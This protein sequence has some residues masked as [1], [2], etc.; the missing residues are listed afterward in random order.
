[1]Q[2]RGSIVAL[3]GPADHRTVR[4]LAEATGRVLLEFSPPQGKGREAALASALERMLK[5]DLIVKKVMCESRD[6]LLRNYVPASL[7]EA[8]S[9]EME[10]YV[11]AI[12]QSLPRPDLVLALGPVPRPPPGTVALVD[13]GHGDL[14]ERATTVVKSVFVMPGAGLS[15]Y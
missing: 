6:V 3:V 8:E 4:R 12:H 5:R 10:A 13:T 11:L 2:K 7:A 14:F 9:E 15:F 1:M